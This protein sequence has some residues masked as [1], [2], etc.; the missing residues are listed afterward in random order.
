MEPHLDA[1]A[2]PSAVVA[3]LVGVA[4]ETLTEARWCG[5][6][7]LKRAAGC[8]ARALVN[9]CSR[10]TVGTGLQPEGPKSLISLF[11][12]LTPSDPVALT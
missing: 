11:Q 12:T 2:T 7:V 4:P 3:D 9:A 8:G 5:E 6:V 10:I 1:A